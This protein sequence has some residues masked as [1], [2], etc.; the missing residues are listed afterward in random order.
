MDTYN[1]T[2]TRSNPWNFKIIAIFFLTCALILVGLS[3]AIGQGK[4]K[5]QIGKD[6]GNK[7]SGMDDTGGPGISTTKDFYLRSGR[8]PPL[9][10]GFNREILDGKKVYRNSK[11]DISRIE[12]FDEYGNVV[13][14]EAFKD[15]KLAVTDEWFYDKKGT[16]IKYISTD[17]RT[18]RV[19]TTHHNS[20]GIKYSR[21]TTQPGKPDVIAYFDPVLGINVIKEVIY[22]SNGEPERTFYFDD[23]GKMYKVENHNPSNGKDIKSTKGPS[24]NNNSGV[25]KAGGKPPLKPEPDKPGS[26]ASL[27]VGQGRGS[28]QI[29]KDG[30]YKDLND[31]IKD[32]IKK[33]KPLPKKPP[34]KDGKRIYRNDRGQIHK[35]EYFDENRKRVKNEFYYGAPTPYVILHFDKDG[36]K[37]FKEENFMDGKPYRTIERIIDKKGK[38]IKTIYRNHLT[39]EKSTTYFNNKGNRTL[40][41]TTFPGKPKVVTYYDNTGEHVVK[42]V[43]YGQDG[44]PLATTYFGKDGT[45]MKVVYGKDGKPWQTIW[46]DDEGKRKKVEFHDLEKEKDV[47]STKGQDS[48]LKKLQDIFG[49]GEAGKPGK[50]P[51]KSRPQASADIPDLDDFISKGG[52]MDASSNSPI[53]PGGEEDMG[54]IDPALD[55]DMGRAIE[56]DLQKVVEGGATGPGPSEPVISV[57]D[58][59]FPA[60]A[61]EMPPSQP[62][63]NMP[64]ESSTGGGGEM[65]MVDPPVTVIEIK[66]RE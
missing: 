25:D 30:E 4:G 14:E 40:M 5:G 6:G 26:Q 7:G 64:V 22:G 33:S 51:V 17:H 21:L 45:K 28:G 31:V 12:Y 65:Q 19:D 15:G 37:I 41:V 34:I 42:K 1:G 20:Q 63:M 9:S 48:E 39:G 47:K 58:E 24:G 66:P 11:G 43:E 53:M 50:K 46:F 18:G 56:V 38:H 10:P 44:N 8:L 36:K 55:P 62:D 52:A 60:T 27:G 2:A 35:I 49:G 3:P 57:S 59:P 29:G 61:V 13:K 32:G 23:N 54:F 16:R